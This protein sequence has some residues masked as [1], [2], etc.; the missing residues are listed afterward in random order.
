MRNL[1]LIILFIVSLL[2]VCC[3]EDYEEN[4][5]SES[6]QVTKLY[7][8]IG[9]ESESRTLY[10]YDE[11]GKLKVYWKAGDKIRAYKTSSSRI[12]L[13]LSEGANTKNATFTS[14][15]A[16]SPTTS[17][18]VYYPY[19]TSYTSPKV[20]TTQTQTGNG[21]LDHLANY[22]IMKATLASGSDKLY[23]KH[24]VAIMKVIVKIPDE[25][26]S[27]DIKSISLKG[28]YGST[29]TLN[30]GSGTRCDQNKLL[31]AYVTINGGSYTDTK[32]HLSVTLTIKISSSK[33]KSYTYDY[34]N[35]STKQVYEYG[36]MYK[37]NFA[38]KGLNLNGHEAIDLGLPSGTLWATSSISKYQWGRTTT[39]NG[40]W[41][42][43]Y[44]TKPELC[45]GGSDPLREYVF[46]NYPVDGI[47]AS[48]FDA[49]TVNWGG[50]WQMPTVEDFEELFR[51][52]NVQYNEWDEWDFANAFGSEHIFTG[53]NGNSLSLAIDSYVNSRTTIYNY[54]TASSTKDDATKA[55][56]YHSRQ[57]K[58]AER[59]NAYHIRPIIR[60]KK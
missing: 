48:Q 56:Y 14:T 51:Y 28:V 16:L 10:E 8:Q 34:R 60:K 5:N 17:Y 36:K 49:A 31:T 15:T 11:S 53:P 37:V 55:I 41:A 59:A 22:N 9:E 38:E 46:P 13:T 52:C 24:Q 6:T 40:G 58:A 35:P 26:I 19:T 30:F 39:N 44:V 2:T 20:T 21:T 25:E 47:Q 57:L 32:S 3:S 54:W 29:Y 4:H 43:Y 1:Q 23:F 33:T 42:A 12:D 7:A 27:R 45:G 18:T 50:D